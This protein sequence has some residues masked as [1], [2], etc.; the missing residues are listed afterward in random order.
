LRLALPMVW[1]MDRALPAL[2]QV[3][4]LRRAPQRPLRAALQR[5]RPQPVVALEQQGLPPA[6]LAQRT[7]RR[8][9]QAAEP[10]W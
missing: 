1:R 2:E 3:L 9:E 7:D 5:D 4:E 6:R 8:R 10:P